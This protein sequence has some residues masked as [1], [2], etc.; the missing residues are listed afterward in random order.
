MA[1][2]ELRISSRDRPELEIS[3]PRLAFGSRGGKE[4]AVVSR[5]DSADVARAVSG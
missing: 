3:S 4:I 1:S 5:V 2:G